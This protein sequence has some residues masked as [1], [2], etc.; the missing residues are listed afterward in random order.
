GWSLSSTATSATYLDGANYTAT[1][2]SVNLYAVWTSVP[3]RAITFHK[4][5]GSGENVIQQVP[6]NTISNLA[7]NTFTRDLYVFIGWSDT[8]SGSVLYVDGAEYP[9]GNSN[10]NF[11]AVWANKRIITFHG[12]GGSIPITGD[13]TKTQE[14]PEDRAIA[15]AANTF[16]KTFKGE[17]SYFVGWSL[18]PTGTVEYANGANY[19]AGTENVDLYARWSVNS[20]TITFDANEGTGGPTTVEEAVYG[21]PMPDLIGQ[22]PPTRA[23]GYVFLGYTDSP[24]GGGIYYTANLTSARDW[25]MTSDTNIT[26]YARWVMEIKDIVVGM[27]MIWIPAGTFWMGSSDGSGT[28][29]NPYPAEGRTNEQPRHEV[30]LTAGFY[31][32]K[33]EVTQD[34]YFAVMGS[35]PSSFSSSPYGVEIQG[36]RPVEQVSW[37]D[38]L[39]FC[40]KLSEKEGLSPAYRINS[41]TDPAAWGTVPTSSN[42]TWDAV[43]IVS[44]STGYR[45][46]TESQWEYACRAGTT[47]VYNTGATIDDTAGWYSSNSN[48]MTHQVGL[49]AV[50]AFGLYDMHGNV[51]E[52]CYNWYTSGSVR[53]LRGGSWYGD[54]SN[55]RSAYRLNDGPYSRY[56]NIG[57]RVVR[58]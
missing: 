9:M 4:N 49:K 28:P 23:G 18:T 20:Y 41:S 45:L 3:L 26:L 12:N 30:T 22:T 57:F 6:E 17:E 50:N 25:D 32:G 14:A 47:T 7:M 40:N 15:L 5:D 21:S 37:Y 43:S 48:N 33:Y 24:T 31:M 56:F 27:N 42:A 16:A 11:Y 1:E 58:P 52:W 36:K 55:M 54:A 10:V 38:A 35:N 13:V 46:P 29:G 51:Y 53:V 8:P 39:V 19:T 2:S 34:E 44:G